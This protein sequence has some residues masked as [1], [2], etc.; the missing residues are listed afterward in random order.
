MEWLK[1]KKK[2]NSIFVEFKVSRFRMN[3]IHDLIV[4]CVHFNFL[5]IHV[6]IA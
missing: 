4:R 1:L 3:V 5:F 2:K 6:Y